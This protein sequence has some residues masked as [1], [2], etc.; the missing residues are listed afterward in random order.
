MHGGTSTHLSAAERDLHTPAGCIQGPAVAPV[1]H[2]ERPPAAPAHCWV[3]LGAMPSTLSFSCFALT[4]APSG[5][6][7]ASRASA[8]A[9]STLNDA[10]IKGFIL[11]NFSHNWGLASP[12]SAGQAGGLGGSGCQGSRG[13][14]SSLGDFGVALGG[15]SARCTASPTLPGLVSIPVSHVPR[16][17]PR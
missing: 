10:C 7:V 8:A 4:T 14:I 6:R 9:P 1:H 12:K 11:R 17:Q 2:G 15:P 13:R 3:M 5:P 16:C